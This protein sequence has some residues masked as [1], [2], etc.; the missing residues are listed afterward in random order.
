L[1]RCTYDQGKYDESEKQQMKQTFKDFLQ[2]IGQAILQASEKLDGSDD[3]H[4]YCDDNY[5]NSFQQ[6]ETQLPNMF[7]YEQEETDQKI[8]R[9][10]TDDPNQENNPDSFEDKQQG[11]N[12]M[13]DDPNNMEDSMQD[14]PNNM[15][16]DPERQGNVRYVKDAHLVSR[17]EN[18]DGQFE[19]LW[20][21]NTGSG[22]KRR[23]D[24]I[25]QDILKGTDIPP[26]EISSDDGSQDYLTW[27]V[28]NVQMVKV[29]GLPE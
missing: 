7:G 26:N 15:E 1:F 27:N 8:Q 6:P 18:E 22:A 5:Q 23:S 13:E 10:S 24:F 28:G 11:R 29:R 16:E 2:V 17:R 19:E 4:Q 9:T 21:F 20:I 25:I 14:D 3:E 12:T